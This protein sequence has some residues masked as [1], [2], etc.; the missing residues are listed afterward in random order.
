[1]DVTL[2]EG[3]LWVKP[4][5]REKV[6]L[7][8]ESAAK[9]FVDGVEDARFIFNKNMPGDVISLTRW[10]FVEQVAQRVR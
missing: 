4:S 10:Q 9:F 5:K 8:P 1:F 2:E 3:A 7:I 6:R